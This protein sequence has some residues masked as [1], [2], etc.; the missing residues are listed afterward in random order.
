M[1]DEGATAFRQLAKSE[2]RIDLFLHPKKNKC[3]EF[4]SVLTL[5]DQ[6][7]S[8]TALLMGMEVIADET[9]AMPD[10]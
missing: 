2:R 5:G 1:I 6:S 9:T 3:T 4:V 8:G 10:Y 7:L